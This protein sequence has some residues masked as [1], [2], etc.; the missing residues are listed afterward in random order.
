MNYMNLN[1]EREE[2]SLSEILNVP[3]NEI[4]LNVAFRP[5]SHCVLM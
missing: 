5:M 4:D 2:C 1:F 3:L